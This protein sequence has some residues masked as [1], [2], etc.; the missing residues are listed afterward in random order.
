MGKFTDYHHTK[1][2]MH[3]SN[4]SLVITNKLKAKRII[5]MTTTLL[6]ILQKLLLLLT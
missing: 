4:I 6:C 5:G 3:D 2:H 1:F